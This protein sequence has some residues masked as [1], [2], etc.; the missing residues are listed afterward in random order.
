MTQAC[1]QQSNIN[2]LLGLRLG[3]LS[4]QAQ[5][6]LFPIFLSLDPILSICI[7]FQAQPARI[8]TNGAIIIVQI[9]VQS[10]DPAL[11]WPE[12]RLL[13]PQVIGLCLTRRRPTTITREVLR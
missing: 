7:A 1:S 13:L 3:E 8:P 10:H 12:G 2:P 11:R 6:T 9:A 5:N 4:Q